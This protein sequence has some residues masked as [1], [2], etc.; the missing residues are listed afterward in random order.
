MSKHTSTTKTRPTHGGMR[1]D[2]TGR[3]HA[4]EVRD[5]IAEGIATRQMP[6]TTH[7]HTAKEAMNMTM[8][9]TTT[10]VPA[11]PIQEVLA[12][13]AAITQQAA[14]E[15]QLTAQ[16]KQRLAEVYG[17]LHD[18][19]ALAGDAAGDGAE[20]H[21]QEPEP[22]VIR[23]GDVNRAA[24]A[25]INEARAV[26]GLEAQTCPP[27]RYGG[28]SA[29][30]NTLTRLT[31]KGGDPEA[32]VELTWD[33]L[34][35]WGRDQEPHLVAAGPV[36]KYAIDFVA[37]ALEVRN[38]D[39]DTVL[40]VAPTEAYEATPVAKAAAVAKAEG[41]AVAVKVTVSAATQ[42]ATRALLATG[43]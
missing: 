18:T 33:G 16:M 7:N 24:L 38:P 29:W 36:D 1:R 35:V 43:R 22:E 25:M 3:R 42:A 2:H 5:Q 12:Q 11:S 4:N 30:D 10:T 32:Q 23:A 13:I 27:R 37:Q 41:R 19:A 39:M 26:L 40:G 20:Q 17:R 14:R 34:V 15:G 31:L 6:S 9:T 8:T 21:D 28:R